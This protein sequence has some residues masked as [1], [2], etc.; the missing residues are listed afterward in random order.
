MTNAIVITDLIPSTENYNEYL[1]LAYKIM[2]DYQ[3]VTS[4]KKIIEFTKKTHFDSWRLYCKNIYLLEGKSKKFYLSLINALE[5]NTKNG[6]EIYFNRHK[7]SNLISKLSNLIYIP[8]G[9]IL[10]KN[11]NNYYHSEL[12][13][14]QAVEFF[15]LLELITVYLS[16]GLDVEFNTGI[17]KGKKIVN[18]Y[19]FLISEFS[20]KEIH[21]LKAIKKI[22]N[23]AI[24][25]D[26]KK[27]G[28]QLLSD[29]E[30]QCISQNLS[31]SESKHLFKK[32][33][34]YS[35]SIFTSYL[36]QI[37]IQL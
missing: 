30:N 22:S 6:V 14:N 1:A 21:C 26:R 34:K 36:N 37:L 10:L 35:Y 2:K 24:F 9:L 17:V 4:P 23:L 7:K 13:I 32:V 20:E 28:N 29:F 11:F 19:D 12:T 8:I 33:E 5:L 18:P 25:L 16:A 27:A 31:Q 15:D 3:Y